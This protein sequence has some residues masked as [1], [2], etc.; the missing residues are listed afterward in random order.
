[1]VIQ[2]KWYSSLSADLQG[3]IERVSQSLSNRIKD[4]INR[5]ENPIPV[6]TKE[7]E[8][9]DKRVNEHLKRMGLSW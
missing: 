1:M 8:K 7:V 5:Y 2:D 3:E 9:Y 4:L 6:L